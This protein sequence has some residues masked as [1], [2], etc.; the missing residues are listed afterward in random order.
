[1]SQSL[2]TQRQIAEVA[3]GIPQERV[4]QRTTEQSVKDP[5]PQDVKD[6]VKCTM[7]QIVN[8]PTPQAVEE[9]R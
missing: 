6:I 5:T 8:G 1:M 9:N 7:E 3:L 4:Q 2:K